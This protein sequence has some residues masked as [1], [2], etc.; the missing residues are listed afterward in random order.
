[1][2]EAQEEKVAY[3]RLLLEAGTMVE[4]P[5]VA[6]SRGGV[7][8]TSYALEREEAGVIWRGG[9]GTPHI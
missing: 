4:A 9:V 2:G 7:L 8:Q 5:V 1:M 6:V 3:H